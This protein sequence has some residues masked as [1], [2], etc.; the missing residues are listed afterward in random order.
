M[1]KIPQ[2]D[3]AP[4]GL[5]G[6]GVGDKRHHIISRTRETL[7]EQEPSASKAKD[8]SSGNDLM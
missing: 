8:V 7:L 3:V 1:Y 6:R 2:Q 5:E 4:K